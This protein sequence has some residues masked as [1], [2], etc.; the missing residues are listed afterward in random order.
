MKT[1]TAIIGI[2]AGA[3]LALLTIAATYEKREFS[4]GYMRQKLAYSQ[5][6]MEGLTLEKFDLVTK[7]GIRIRNMKLTNMMYG[8]K[9]PGYMRHVTNYQ[10][11][12]DLLLG[13]SVDKDLARAT[14]A[15]QG[16]I[17]S[18]VECH[19]DYR[20]EQRPIPTSAKD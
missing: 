16:I 7:N 8:L 9:Q 15:Y 14:K 11:T 2:I 19:R 3:A 4:R 20:T 17:Q 10:H 18:C 12:V 5:G 6:V 13:A 1:K